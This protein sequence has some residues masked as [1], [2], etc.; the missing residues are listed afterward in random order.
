M[1]LRK[2]S[3]ENRLSGSVMPKK[4]RSLDYKTSPTL[5][6]TITNFT[7]SVLIRSFSSVITDESLL[8]KK[9]FLTYYSY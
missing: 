7:W 5:P 6:A 8:S 3:S 2:I 4:N 9:L 1:N